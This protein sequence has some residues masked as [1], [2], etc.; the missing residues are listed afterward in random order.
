MIDGGPNFARVERPIPITL[1]A[2]GVRTYAELY[3]LPTD[4]VVRRLD[5]KQVPLHPGDAFLAVM[6][7]RAV[8]ELRKSAERLDAAGH[9]FRTASIAL[10]VFAV[11]VAIAQLIAAIN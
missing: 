3:D 6:L 4:D 7:L 9:N 5:E 8:V 11:A 1:E 10:A 2:A